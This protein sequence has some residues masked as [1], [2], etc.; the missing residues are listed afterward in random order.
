MKMVKTENVSYEYTKV[1][2]IKGENVERKLMALQDINIDIEKGDFIAILGHNGSGKSTFAKHLNA[3]VTPSEGTIWVDG[4][5][6]KDD[7]LVW[8]IRQN[9]GMVF[10]NPDNQLVATVVEEDIAFG[11]ENLGVD[12]KEIRKRVDESLKQVGMDGFQTDTPSKLS[13]GQKQ[14][15][16]IAGILA[17][18]PQ[19]IVLDE[20][21]AMLDP[22]GRKDV[23]DTVHRLN[24]ENNITII[25]IT[26]YMDEAVSADKVYVIDDGKIVMKGVPKEVFSQVERMKSYGLDVPQVTETAYNLRKL[27]IDIPQDIL[28]VEEMVGAI[29]QLKSTI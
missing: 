9:T 10:Q 23:M 5:D 1:V 12:P 17:M 2:E 26:H 16:A 28:T 15:I 18:K 27:G 24:K 13:G 19:C 22:V 21:T 4:M 8:K 29:C 14:R 6:T 11:P 3:L 25:L 7:S 20:P